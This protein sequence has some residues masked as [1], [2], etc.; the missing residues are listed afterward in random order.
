M[1]VFEGIEERRQILG[2]GKERNGRKPPSNPLKAFVRYSA[3]Q[4]YADNLQPVS[5][6]DRVKT[7]SLREFR[8]VP[9]VSIHS[10]GY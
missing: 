5:A 6:F 7:E 9:V 2:R 3:N 10:V 8:P 1:E 4:E